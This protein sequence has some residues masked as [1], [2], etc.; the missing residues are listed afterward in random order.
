MGPYNSTCKA[1]KLAKMKCDLF[2]GSKCRSRGD[3]ENMRAE[4][5]CSY[6][7][8]RGMPCML[9]ERLTSTNGTVLLSCFAA[10]LLCCCAAMLLC[11]CAAVLLCCYAVVMLCCC[12]GVMLRCCDAVLL[13]C[14][15]A[16][17][18]CCCDASRMHSCPLSSVQGRAR[19]SS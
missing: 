4:K 8:H 2:G 18:L 6:C 19:R 13:C 3:M 7:L 5:S 11:C 9:E 10:V 17:M 12:D 16:V 15:A 1:C 14:C